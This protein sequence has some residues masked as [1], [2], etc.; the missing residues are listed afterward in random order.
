MQT[1]RLFRLIE[2][3]SKKKREKFLLF[4]RSPYFNQHEKTTELLEIILANIGKKNTKKLEKE[5]VF[6]KL[7]PKD[8]FDEQQIHNLM[9]YLKKLYNKFTAIQCL[10]EQEYEEQLFL[11]E[12]ATKNNQAD[13]LKNRS[14]QLQKQLKKNSNTDSSFLYANYRMYK[15]LGYYITEYEDR[16][17]SEVLQKMMDNFNYYF[18]AEMLENCCHLRANMIML[19][20]SYHFHF[21]DELLQYLEKN[22]SVYRQIPSIELYYTILMSLIHE[23]NDQHYDDLKYILDNKTHLLSTKEGH[24]SYRFAYNYCI[25]KINSGDSAYQEELFN[26]YNTGLET[27]LIFQNGVLS[28]WDYK[29]I[30]T[31]GCSFKK[32]E[33]TKD[34][35]ETYNSK[36]MPNRQ[37]NA[38]KFNMA[39]LYYN[40]KEYNKTLELLLD[41][42][43]P[44][45]KYNL[46]TNFL[47]LRTF[48]AMNNTESSLS[49]IEA[50]RIYVMR[51]KRM[52]TD[53][54][55]GYTNL[56]RF[57]KKLVLL[58]PQAQTYSEKEFGEK[59]KALKQKTIDAD[60]VINKFW[61]LEELEKLESGVTV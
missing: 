39:N 61:I 36:L 20:S 28:E 3:L 11:L 6:K 19:N 56:L 4:V 44:D 37:E 31:L 22:W 12:A 51:N 55:R 60:N 35:I 34:F 26:L 30:A 45:V 54:K 21:L 2:D 58:R 41:V 32:F 13:F 17:D 46:T 42:D 15:I 24:D 52:T 40:Q 38:Y 48:Y 47:I 1:S 23:E 53:Q 29:N 33:W 10:E 14:K 16:A 7:F 5:A 18:I 50:F 9:S 25:R 27:G 57:A 59:I 8:K 49:R 43:F